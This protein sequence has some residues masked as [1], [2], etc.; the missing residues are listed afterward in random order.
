MNDIN[1]VVDAEIVEAAV[2]EAPVS[3][4]PG[5]SLRA[6]LNPVR[7]FDEAYDEYC[8]RRKSASYAV[9]QYLKRGTLVHNS[10]PD[11]KKKGVTYRKPKEQ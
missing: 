3:E 9:K 8:Q 4:T 2:V 6:L 1:E 10:I 7:G 11:P 5:P